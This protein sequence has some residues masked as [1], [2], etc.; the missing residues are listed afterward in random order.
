MDMGTVPTGSKTRSSANVRVVRC[1][2][3]PSSVGRHGTSNAQTPSDD[4]KKEKGTALINEKK[5]K[6]IVSG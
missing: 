4:N 1:A 3:T 5:R 6:T 2:L